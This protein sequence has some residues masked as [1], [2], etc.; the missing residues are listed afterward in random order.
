[1]AQTVRLLNVKGREQLIERFY[2]YDG[3]CAIKDGVVEI[4]L[5]RPEWVQRAYILGYRQDP[6]D[7]HVLTLAEALSGGAEA[8]A[9]TQESAEST[10]DTDEGSD[11]GG[12]S[13][14][15]DGLRESEPEGYEGFYETFVGSGVGDGVAVSGSG[16]ESSPDAVHS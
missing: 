14:G 11:V 8:P 12:Q 7:E 3:E 4:P 5:D 9:E 2:F 13:T 16:D 10:G 1:M 6:D 15:P